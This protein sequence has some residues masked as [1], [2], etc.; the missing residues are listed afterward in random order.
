M[1]SDRRTDSQEPQDKVKINLPQILAATGASTT[2]AIVASLMGI[3]GTVAGVAL[4]SVVSSLAT[5]LYLHSMNRTK[6]RLAKVVKR[7]TV[8]HIV[9]ARLPETEE[10]RPAAPED[11][12]ASQ[13]VEP[14]G[15]EPSETAELD[16]TRALPVQ[17]RAD[18]G[19][20][21]TTFETAEPDTDAAPAPSRVN[22]RMAA[23]SSVAVFALS[24][25]VLSAIALMSGKPPA[26]FY[27]DD[28]GSGPTPQEEIDQDDEENWTTPSQES[29][30]SPQESGS[31]SEP[32]PQ[33]S[34]PSPSEPEPTTSEP[35]PTPP[36]PPATSDDP[37]DPPT[38]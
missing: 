7:G 14:D 33:E 17:S 24:I 12:T 35:S 2:A 4:F 31:T 20:V 8:T 18:G 29:P 22:W 23:I 32:S 10:L 34:S 26:A 9:V 25:A 27:G 37:V 16:A 30:S 15:T 6:E 13:D 28:S 38:E 3:S 21:T 1:S 19:T 36:S 5:V 11:D